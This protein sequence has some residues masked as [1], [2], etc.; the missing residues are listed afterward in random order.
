MAQDEVDRSG[1][2][3]FR[4]PRASCNC[5]V[6]RS[7]SRVMAMISQH[8]RRPKRPPRRVPRSFGQSVEWFIVLTQL[9]TDGASNTLFNDKMPAATGPFIPSIRETRGPVILLICS[10]ADTPG[11]S[12]VFVEETRQYDR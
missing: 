3:D 9:A 6:K 1:C 10:T 7:Y 5:F 4:L 11:L 8:C 12:P 2:H